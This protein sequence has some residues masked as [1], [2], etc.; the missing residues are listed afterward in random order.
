MSE[1]RYCGGLKRWN[2]DVLP[3]PLRLGEVGILEA[4]CGYDGAPSPRFSFVCPVCN[5]GYAAGAKAATERVLG[6]VDDIYRSCPAWKV[7]YDEY[8]AIRR[9]VE[10]GD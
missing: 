9:R 1:C 3:E 2:G 5:D 4:H 6:I 8:M 10:E 7:W